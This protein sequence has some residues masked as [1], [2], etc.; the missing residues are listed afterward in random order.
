MHTL[1]MLRQ[2][3]LVVVIDLDDGD[4]LLREIGGVL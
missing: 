3:G 4:T 1:Q 2:A